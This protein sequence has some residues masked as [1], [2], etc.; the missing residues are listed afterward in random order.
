MSTNAVIARPT[1]T[2]FEGRYHHFD[3]YP[4]GLGREL[5]TLMQ[6][7]NA[8]D[9]LVSLIDEHPAGWSNIIGANWTITP[10]YGTYGPNCYCHGERAEAARPLITERSFDEMF[11]E[12]V[13][14]IDLERGTMKVISMYAN[15]SRVVHL[16]KPEPL[17]DRLF[18]EEDDDEVLD[19]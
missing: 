19:L 14:V 12:Y 1:E 11:I 16:N 7:S 5:F 10:G 6:D 9:T 17:W 4:D 13:Y 3:G 18:E 15:D 2:G 8:K